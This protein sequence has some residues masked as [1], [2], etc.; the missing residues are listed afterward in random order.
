MTEYPK[1]FEGTARKN[2]EKFLLPMAGRPNLQFLQIGAF[3]G[4]ASVWMLENVLT[5]PSSLLMDV[6]TWGGSDEADH[7]EFDWHDVHMTYLTRMNKYPNVR[8]Y[9]RS[10]EGFFRAGYAAPL[11]PFDFIYIDGDHR[12][13]SVLRDAM[14]AFDCLKVGGILAFDDYT[15]NSQRGPFY[16]PGPG[17]DAFSQIYQPFRTLLTI[18]WQYWLRKDGTP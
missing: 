9:R 1:W 13:P 12:A 6:D 5:D 11:P 15:W 18:D 4:D 17:I 8:A 2:F 14:S 3:T 7:K 16:N 10:S